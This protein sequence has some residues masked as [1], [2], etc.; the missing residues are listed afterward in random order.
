[1]RR[2]DSIAVVSDAVAEVLRRSGVSSSRVSAVRN[3]VEIRRFHG[4][5]PALRDQLRCGGN[6]LVGFVG[7]LVPDKGGALLLRAAQ[8]L[9]AV[10]ADVTFILVGEG[11][12]RSEWEA[13]ARYLGIGDRVLFTGARVDMPGVYAS[14]DIVVLPSLVEA[15]PMCVLEAMAAGRP[16][17]ATRVGAVP[18]M[19]DPDVT[20]LLLDPG[21]VSGLVAAISRLLEDRELARRL[22]KNGHAYVAH[23]FSDE[24]MAMSY[25]EIYEHALARY[26][27]GQRQGLWQLG[28]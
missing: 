3:G 18:K 20:G 19:I 1:L 21:D 15:M 23:H 13:M 7:R 2:F 5:T 6:R 16:V 25:I 9:L 14:L 4:A 8:K 24:A 22:G 28:T 26:G 12:S 27:L 11:P 10:Y 17:I